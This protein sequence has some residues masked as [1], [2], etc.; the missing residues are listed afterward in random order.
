MGELCII[1]AALAFSF[2]SILTKLAY[3]EYI[4]EDSLI[5]FRLLLSYV[6]VHLLV[7]LNKSKISLN[8]KPLLIILIGGAF[9]YYFSPILSMK[10]L[11]YINANINGFVLSLYPFFVIILNIILNKK[12]PT[13]LEL[14]YGFFIM[15]GLYM[16]LGYE[17]YLSTEPTYI[18]G[19]IFTILAT[20]LFAVYVII[21]QSLGNKIDSLGFVF[22]AILGSLII[23]AFSLVFNYNDTIEISQMGAAIIFISAIFQCFTI[24]LLAKGISIIGANKASLI[25]SIHP[26]FTLLFAFIILQETLDTTQMVGGIIILFVILLLGIKKDSS[27]T[28]IAKYEK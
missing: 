2:Q 22:Y 9:G 14:I 1:L 15:L 25:S 16:L 7:K 24:Y 21:N 17:T 27:A 18:L 3:E 12:Y 10:G 13:K 23:S 4:N 20:V 6:F 5:F 28:Q 26:I 8:Y 19:I 11:K